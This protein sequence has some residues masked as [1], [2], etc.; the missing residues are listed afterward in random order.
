MP[1]TPERVHGLMVNPYPPAPRGTTVH[2][3]DAGEPGHG[4]WWGIAIILIAVI[5]AVAFGV[6]THGDGDVARHVVAAQAMGPEGTPPEVTDD[7]T[8]VG[9]ADGVAFPG[10]LAQQGWLPVSGRTDQVSDRTVTTV[11]YGREG[12]RLAYSIVS[13]P[14]LGAPPGSRSVGGRAPVVRAFDADGRSAVMTVREGHSI[15][16]SAVGVPLAAL[17]RAARTD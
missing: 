4:L 3:G 2:S 14:P 12:R 15:V 5:V 1:C 7:G 10:L 13:G 9:T 11:V 16:V 17:V 6:A 8:P